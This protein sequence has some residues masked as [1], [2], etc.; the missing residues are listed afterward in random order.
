MRVGRKKKV[1]RKGIS[2]VLLTML[3]VTSV[4]GMLGTT[5]Q[6]KAA[7]TTLIVHYGGREDNNYDNWNLWIWEE[8]ADGQTVTFRAEAIPTLLHSISHASHKLISSGRINVFF[9]TRWISLSVII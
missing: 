5:L 8:G 1:F 9:D 6:V 4:L 3:I 7:G 2:M